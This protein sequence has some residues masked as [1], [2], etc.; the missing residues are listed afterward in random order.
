MK[1]IQIQVVCYALSMQD[2]PTFGVLSNQGLCH[3]CSAANTTEKFS[4]TKFS[5][6]KSKFL[7]YGKTSII[8][9][10]YMFIIEISY[11]V[12]YVWHCME[13]YDKKFFINGNCMIRSF[14]QPGHVALK[15]LSA[16]FSLSYLECGGSL[17]T[18]DKVIS[19]ASCFYN[20]GE[21]K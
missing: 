17:I 16:S 8:Q 19:S 15:V 12:L 20:K 2:C 9:F 4:E 11:N 3:L 10:S 21:V 5:K 6:K 14:G 7:V 1:N 13:L 18:P